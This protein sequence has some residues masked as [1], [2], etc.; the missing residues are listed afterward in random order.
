MPKTVIVKKNGDIQSLF[1]KN[2]EVKDLHKKCNFKSESNF[3]Q[4]HSWKYKKNNI[5]V[6][7]KNIGRHNHINKYEFPPPIDN[8]L[9]YGN[10]I[11]VKTDGDDTN[12]YMDLTTDEWEE[13]YTFLYGGFEDLDDND[14]TDDVD[15]K[16]QI[17]ME[18][19]IP[20]EIKTQQGYVKDNFI[21][22]DSSVD[23]VENT[24]EMSEED[25]TDSE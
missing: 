25:F 3:C 24:S 20:P 14:T 5:S 11:L 9:I 21:V 13:I 10:C 12:N 16:E 7:G 17:E 4:L 22:E 8:L 6:Y 2:L 18:K 1:V 19:N 23:D 15:E